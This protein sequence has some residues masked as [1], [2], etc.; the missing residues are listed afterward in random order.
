MN[1]G[2]LLSK[3]TE[4]DRAASL[5]L[6]TLPDPVLRL[7]CEPVDAF[8]R[9]FCELVAEMRQLMLQHRG[10]GLAAPQVGVALRFFIGE[11]D[12]RRLSVVNPRL[13]P[14][15]AAAEEGVEGCLS[16]PG[17]EVPVTRTKAVMV[18]GQTPDGKALSLVVEGFWARLVQHEVD[19]LNG[20][21]I[22]DYA[23]TATEPEPSRTRAW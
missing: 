18:R 21:L 2:N 17:V 8:D 13:Q 6:R 3:K 7:V 16:L 12:G 9:P 19:H 4:P 14:C 22:C 20:R 5:A 1:V 10:I 11:I 15:G 23:P